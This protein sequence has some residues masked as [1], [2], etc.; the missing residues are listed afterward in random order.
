MVRSIHLLAISMGCHVAVHSAITSWVE[1]RLVG[2]DLVAPDPK[3]RPCARDRVEAQRGE[4]SAFDD[5]RELWLAES[6]GPPF[7]AALGRVAASV[8]CRVV[9]SRDDEVAEWPGNVELMHTAL[10]ATQGLAWI[11]AAT[12]RTVR[13][14]GVTVS[15]Q[16]G[17]EVHESLADNVRFA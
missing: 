14:H 10:A 13:D 12:G 15:V 2:L 8:P 9:Y 17:D 3:Y 5:A 4:R 11:E 7:T 16:H 6:A 1:P